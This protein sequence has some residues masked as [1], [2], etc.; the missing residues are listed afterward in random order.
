MEPKKTASAERGIIPAGLDPATLVWLIVLTL[1]YLTFELAFNA[2]L[3]DVVGGAASQEEIDH[4]EFYGRMLSGTAAALFL[5]QYLLNRRATSRVIMFSCIAC[6]FV[7]YHSL[8]SFVDHVV[9]SSTPVFRR[10]AA[11]LVLIQ[12]GLVNNRVSLAGIDEASGLYRLPEGKA[13]LA[14]FPLLSVSVEELDRKLEQAELQLLR[15]AI[16]K[17]VGGIQRYYDNYVKAI[18][19][20]SKQWRKYR[21][22]DLDKEIEKKHREA[23][24]EYTGNL[25]KRRWTVK[26]VASNARL[27]HAMRDEMRKKLK[28]LP[29]DWRADDEGAV[30]AAVAREV[31][32]EVANQVAKTY[33]IPLNLSQADFIAAPSVQKELRENLSLPRNVRVPLTAG[34]QDFI[35]LYDS[36]CLFQAEKQLQKYNASVDSFADGGKNAVM[37]LDAARAAL[38]PPIALFFSLM[39]A[40][41][42]LG[43]LCYLIAKLCTHGRKR[44]GLWLL[45]LGLLVLIW[46]GFSHMENRVTQSRLYDALQKQV[47]KNTERYWR[48]RLILNAIHVVAVGQGVAYPLNESLRI[49]VLRGLTFGYEPKE[50]T[51]REAYAE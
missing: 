19:T 7:V 39:G 26:Y 30:R 38:V 31:R 46:T 25:K 41:G 49:H 51:E 33:R 44:R 16:E 15:T 37:G 20:A 6:I 45:P 14:F 23:W 3:L 34:K 13:F 18:E 9:D 22:H 24:G 12:N 1:I 47:L 48:T 8:Q 4:I 2:R 32:E 43:K 28:Y 40:I 21:G 11:H 5:L 42:H 27:S 29:A 17:E 10:Q 50:K 36:M 35:R